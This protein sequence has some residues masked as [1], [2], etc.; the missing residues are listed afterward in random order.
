M[1][2]IKNIFIYALLL[3]AFSLTGYSFY[4][5]SLKPCDKPIEYSVGSFDQRFPISQDQFKK[6]IEKAASIWE[7]ALGRETFS[8]NPSSSFKIN[9]VYD[10]RQIETIQKQKI[11]SGLDA[12]ETLLKQLDSRFEAAKASY[13]RELSI[14][15][16]KVASFEAD[17]K[18]Y[19]SKVEY[20]NSKGGAPKSQYEALKQEALDLKREADDL[21]TETENLNATAKSLNL[22]LEERNAEAVK[23]NKIAENYNK[24]YGGG[25][26]FDQAVY[27]G[28]AINVYQFI[29]DSDLTL[30]LAH[31]LG[32]ALGMDHVDNPSSIMYYLD[33]QNSQNSLKPSPED[34][35]EL[36]K[37]CGN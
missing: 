15:E 10:Q 18:D 3:A 26:E 9:L 14:H 28:R 34:L 22:L 20:W 35:A 13:E 29:N 31:E 6:D 32:H 24:Q 25:L 19:D 30:A 4:K 27:T 21:N 1:K 16:T 23:Y 37:V 2:A 12:E 11:E 36:H 5:Y 33:G 8:Y 7:G 17:K